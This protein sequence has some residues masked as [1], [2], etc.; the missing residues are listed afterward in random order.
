MTE[1]EIIT[2][3]LERRVEMIELMQWWAGVSFAIIAGSQI[4]ESRLTW[5]LVILMEAFYLFFTVSTMRL[6]R[7]LG[8]QFQAAF[9]D[10]QMIEQPS[11]QALAMLDQF[12]TGSIGTNQLLL[13][14]AALTAVVVTCAYPVW[15][16]RQSSR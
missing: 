9:V 16:L 5:R 3:A 7:S 10:L 12:N 8:V 4:F 13:S 15:L 14:T 6:V 1:F 2:L 11:E